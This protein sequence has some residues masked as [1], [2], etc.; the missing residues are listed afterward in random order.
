MSAGRGLNQVFKDVTQFH[1]FGKHPIGPQN[2]KL[3]MM[4]QT[5]V[6]KVYAY[7][8]R[9]QSDQIKTRVAD[10]SGNVPRLIL[11]VAWM[12]EEI[13]ELLEAETLTGQ[14][15]AILD[16][17]YFA[18]G[19]F[20]EIGFYPGRAFDAVHD[21]NMRKIPADSGQKVQKPYGWVGPEIDIEREVERQQ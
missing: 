17:I 14:I 8:I 7:R 2:G 21:A 1:N 5:L 12:L 6:S 16:L 3:E 19:T 4:E 13:A 15:D 20:V 10:P 9:Q 18:V 11:R